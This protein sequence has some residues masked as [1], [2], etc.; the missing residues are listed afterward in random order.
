LHISKKVIIP[1]SVKRIEYSAFGKCTNL[2]EVKFETNPEYIGLSFHDTNYYNSV[3]EDEYGCKYIQNHVIGFVDKGKKEIV[4]KKDTVSIANSA[5]SEAVF[6]KVVF[7]KELKYIGYSA[8]GFCRK[9][10]RV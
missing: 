2:N 9:L 6:E 8:F 5:F 7:P 10:R 4:I 1:K 3:E